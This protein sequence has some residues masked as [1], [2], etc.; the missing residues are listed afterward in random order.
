MHDSPD[1]RD[2]GCFGRKGIDGI[3]ALPNVAKQAFN[4]VGGTNIPMHDHWEVIKGEQMLCIFH[5]A[6]HRLRIAF[7]IFGLERLQVEKS[8]LFRG[9]F[10]DG[11]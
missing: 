1:K 2:A 9:L 11:R 6:P 4:G 5:Q 10:P 7:M 3:G 8:I